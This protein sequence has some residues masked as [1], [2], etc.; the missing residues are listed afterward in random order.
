VTSETPRR[1]PSKSKQ[2]PAA[3]DE[4]LTL[5]MSREVLKLVLGEL[6]RGGAILD[7]RGYLRKYSWS[8][9]GAQ[10]TLMC[11]ESEPE[12]PKPIEVGVE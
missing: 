9:E 1:P 12:P 5:Q 10:A 2:T 8:I 4:V 3:A 6:N 11:Y 7:E